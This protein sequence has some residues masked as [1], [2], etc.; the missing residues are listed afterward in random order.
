LVVEGDPALLELLLVNLLLAA[1]DI[2]PPDGTVWV[3]FTH[4]RP[5]DEQLA[6]V[7]DA[8]RSW[9]CVQVRCDRSGHALARGALTEC[10][11]IC[12][13]VGGFFELVES[14]SEVT[15]RAFVR[16]TEGPS[17][18]PQQAIAV[19]H[20]D[21]RVRRS[22]VDGLRR[23]GWTVMEVPVGEQ[24]PEDVAVAFVDGKAPRTATE[25][26]AVVVQVLS[27]T[28]PAPADGHYLRVPYLVHELEQLLVR[29]SRG[30]NAR[31]SQ[32]A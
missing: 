30:P 19:V 14:E 11:S 17:V 9:G 25:G 27:R 24:W 22:L 16:A 15:L 32:S 7:R 28:D 26:S 21:E 12:A 6:R 31:G 5:T 1:R 10:Q 13:D 4:A 3:E 20:R 29:V 18:A 2:A 8:G 23:S